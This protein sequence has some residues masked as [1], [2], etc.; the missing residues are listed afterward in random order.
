MLQID[1]LDLPTVAQCKLDSSMSAST[2]VAR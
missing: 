1:W 2:S